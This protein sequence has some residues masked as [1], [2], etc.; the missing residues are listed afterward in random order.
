MQ[1]KKHTPINILKSKNNLMILKK[2]LQLLIKLTK[3]E[4]NQPT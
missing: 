4:L 3:K 2:G 1:T